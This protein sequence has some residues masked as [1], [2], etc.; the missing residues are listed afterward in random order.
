[1]LNVYMR[2]QFKKDYKRMLQQKGHTATQ[3]NDVLELLIRE[4]PLPEKYKDH[5]LKGEYLGYRECHIAPD[6]LLI[7][8]IDAG[9]L[10][11]ILTRTGTHA[12]L[13]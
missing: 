8:K 12:D 4:Q 10:T 11:L 2:S 3:F 6:W 5:K 7:Y 9:A 13:F 1:M